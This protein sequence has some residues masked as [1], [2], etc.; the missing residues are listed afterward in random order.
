VIDRGEPAILVC[1]WPGI[2]FNGER[3]GFNIFKEIVRR[4]NDRYNNLLWMKNSEIARYWAAK[5]L[6]A[7]AR[8]ANRVT[9]TAPFASPR[10]TLSVTVPD[11]AAINEVRVVSAGSDVRSDLKEV[12]GPLKLAPQTWCRQTGAALVCFDLP[13]GTAKVELS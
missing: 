8:E 7:I 11:S 9:L 3:I 5:E 12:A 10:Y 6:T 2:Y 1:H 13:R 4:L